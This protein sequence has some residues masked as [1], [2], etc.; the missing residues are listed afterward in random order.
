MIKILHINKYGNMELVVL[1]RKEDQE[2]RGGGYKFLVTHG[3]TNHSAFYTEQGL[4]RWL[5]A[6]NYRKELVEERENIIIY[7]LIGSFQDISVATSSEQE[8]NRWGESRRLQWTKWLSNGDYTRA[9]YGGGKVY[10]V[11]P[12]YPRV[13]YKYFHE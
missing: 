2:K 12:N 4:D 5:K 11:N 3:A 6:T 10:H 9:Y 13:V 7:Q 8:F 1:K